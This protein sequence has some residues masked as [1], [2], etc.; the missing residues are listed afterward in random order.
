MRQQ[1]LARG[2]VPEPYK[3]P[4]TKSMLIDPEASEAQ[5]KVFTIEGSV[6]KIDEEVRYTSAPRKYESNNE[7]AVIQKSTPPPPSLS[8]PSI[9]ACH[10]V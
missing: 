10:Y 9:P 5:K 8:P 1:A 7:Y 6:Q 2:Q 3:M 4:E